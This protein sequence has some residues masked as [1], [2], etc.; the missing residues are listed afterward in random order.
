MGRVRTGWRLAKAS[1][2]VLRKDGS[3]AMY[4]VV[5][6][7]VALL[8]FWIVAGVGIVVAQ[9]ATV[10]WL[11]L[12]FLLAGIYVAIYVVVY[13][14]VA[15]AAAAQ[16]SIDGR[17]TGLRDGLRVARTRRGIVAQWA[18]LQLTLGLLMS[19]VGALLNDAGARTLSSLV[20]A[21]AGF[22]WSV[23]TFF[24]IPVFALEGLGPRDA[25]ARSVA[26]IRARWGEAVVGRT[27]IG[28]VVFLIALVPIAGLAVLAN[29]LN[30]VNP[31]LAGIAYALFT[32]VALAA[33]ALG[34][35]LSVIFRVE[36]YRWATAGELAGGFA[37]GDVQA[38]FRSAGS[39]Q[40][41]APESAPQGSE[42]QPATDP[43]QAAPGE[44]AL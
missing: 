32:I 44:G 17:D 33:I 40:P 18:L 13:F 7:I 26:L 29:A 8:G 41:E 22:A 37:P 19:I 35:A 16:Q 28:A 42:Q 6:G 34:S 36:V 23:A 4:P 21:A 39:D 12:P 11:V 9:T 30:P 10:P 31:A 3:L 1:W 2:S 43:R 20:S 25:M 15:L 5:A 38:V 24:V 14:S 27:G